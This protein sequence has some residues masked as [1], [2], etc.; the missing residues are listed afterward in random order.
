MSSEYCTAAFIL[1]VTVRV[2]VLYGVTDIGWSI[3]E[4]KS[5]ARRSGAAAQQQ[6]R[7][8]NRGHC[9]LSHGTPRHATAARHYI[10]FYFIVLYCIRCSSRRKVEKC[11]FVRVTAVSVRFVRQFNALGNPLLTVQ[12]F[13]QERT[14]GKCA[15]VRYQRREADIYPQM[16]HVCT[17]DDDD[18]D[19][20][21]RDG[22]ES[23]H[24]PSP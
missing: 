14:C 9:I 2:R 10:V 3:K 15:R 13:V 20:D 4:S 18:D 12:Y 22:V 23:Q 7:I 6:S 17:D 8:A 5:E 19:D 1:W 16:S 24:R 11:S 21:D